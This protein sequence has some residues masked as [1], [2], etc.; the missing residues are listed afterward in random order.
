[1]SDLDAEL[2]HNEKLLWT[3]APYQGVALRPFDGVALIVALALAG[4]AFAANVEQWNKDRVNAVI[5][6]AVATGMVAL[7]CAYV[8]LYQ[9]WRRSRTRYALTDRRAISI[10]RG[11]LGE[12]VRTARLRCVTQ[13]MRVE[14][15]EGYGTLV[16]NPKRPPF[17]HDFVRSGFWIPSD[18][19]FERIADADGVEATLK[20]I[21]GER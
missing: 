8:F 17:E 14:L 2:V 15:P 4:F 1:M 3:G 12:V 13:I 7:P 20:T 18:I 16:F 21:V 5:G 11:W 6:L 10:Y 9:P 19:A